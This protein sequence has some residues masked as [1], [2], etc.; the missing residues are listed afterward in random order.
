MLNKFKQWQVDLFAVPISLNHEGR[1]KANSRHGIF[2]TV[3]FVGFIAWS[4]YSLSHEL[5]VRK[6]PNTINFDSFVETPAPME[7]NKDSF[8]FAFG[9]QLP[10]MQGLSFF[11]DE[12]I[13]KPDVK[14]VVFNT[15]QTEEIS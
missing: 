8:P 15:L 7:L 12:Q 2:L 5:F 14:L 11:K 13:Y 4:I 9:L 3:L 10:I 1:H 6:N